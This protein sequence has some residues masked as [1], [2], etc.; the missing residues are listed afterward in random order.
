MRI[1]PRLFLLLFF[2]ST[3]ASAQAAT[4][5]G[6][7]QLPFQ[8]KQIAPK[9]WAAIDDAK[10]DA[11]AN[12][13]FVVG[14][15][16]VAVIDSFENEAAAKAMLAEI[17]RIT[18]LPIKFVI[19]THYHLDHVAGNAVFAKEG[20]VIAGHQSIR[21][22]IHTENLKF[23]G[24]KI[25]PTEKSLVEHLLAPEVVYDSGVTL[26]LGSRRIDVLHFEG[27][28]GGDSVVNIPDAGVVFCG[29]LFWRKTLPNLIDAT[30]S[31]WVLTLNDIP[32]LPA[33]VTPG[34]SLDRATIFVPGHGDVGNA[35]DV[36][37]F[38]SYLVNLRTLV[39][40][41]VQASKKGD[42]LVAA[43]L[44]DLSKSYGSWDFFKDFSRSNILDMG[45]ELQG[46]KRVPPRAQK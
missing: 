7:A 25:T 46:D 11:G 34:K 35:G 2:G 37:D 38:Q 8:L 44:P 12:A 20:A 22:W 26:Y 28:T 6:G 41:P 31:A 5:T 1:L 40:G 17:R 21:A 24:D 9:V 15:D 10:G 45:S 16:G 39:H 14:D 19:N 32:N 18:P 3:F 29:D 43:V 30:T 13:G 42:E 23:F 33:N 27:H 36:K 4:Q